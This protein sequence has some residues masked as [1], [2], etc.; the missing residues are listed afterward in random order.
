MTNPFDPACYT[1]LYRM[2]AAV[3]IKTRKN[4]VLIRSYIWFVIIL[5]AKFKSNRQLKATYA[6]CTANDTRTGVLYK[7]ALFKIRLGYDSY[8]FVHGCKV[9]YSYL[10]HEQFDGRIVL[11][12]YRATGLTVN[13]NSYASIGRQGKTLQ[14]P[15]RPEDR[16]WPTQTKFRL[17]ITVRWF[18][19]V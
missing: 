5:W 15:K 14:L 17:K 2:V 12:F 6:A 13:E 4:R 1:R 10:Q 16:S 9:L 8:R 3:P 7:T 19:G 11:C 18:H